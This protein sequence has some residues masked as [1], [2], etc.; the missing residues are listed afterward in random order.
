M[1]D[2]REF[3]Y[4]DVKV[5][6]LGA[7]LTG[8]RGLTYKKSQEKEPV[9]GQGNQ[10]KAIQRGNKKYEGSLMLLKS[11]FDR[12][13]TAATLAGYEDITDVPAELITITCTYQKEGDPLVKVDTLIKL[14][15]TEYE[16]G[17]KQGDKFKEVSLPF[18]CLQIKKA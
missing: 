1:F 8:L 15:F 17:M 2:S 16:D 14:E 4:A 6:L 7:E 12:L 11:D 5:K 10:P 3:E 9:Y 18:I 13:N